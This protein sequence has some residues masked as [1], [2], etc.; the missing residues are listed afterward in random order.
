MSIKEK[1][2]NK[3]EKLVCKTF[4]EDGRQEDMKQMYEEKINGQ[5]NQMSIIES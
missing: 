2:V 5:S 3:L 4:L 1:L